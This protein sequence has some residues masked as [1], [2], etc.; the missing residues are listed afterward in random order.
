MLYE[1]ISTGTTSTVCKCFIGHHFSFYLLCLLNFND[2]KSEKRLA[3]FGHVV[4]LDAST[5]AYQVFN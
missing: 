4:R 5:P 1:E 2:V 3:L